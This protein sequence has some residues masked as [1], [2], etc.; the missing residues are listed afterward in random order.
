MSRGGVRC[1]LAVAAVLMAAPAGAAT[2]SASEDAPA[3]AILLGFDDAWGKGDRDALMLPVSPTF[4]CEL[5]GKIDYGKLRTTYGD[6]LGQLPGSTCAT[7]ILRL[8]TIGETTQAFVCRSIAAVGGE[9]LEQLCHV[10]YL[11]QEGPDLKIVGL[12][13]YDAE[14]LD[15]LRGQRYESDAGLF[16]LPVPEGVFLIPCPKIGFALDRVLLRGMDLQCEIELFLLKT[17]RAYDLDRA[18]DTDLQLWAQE[19]APAKIE[20]RTP[21]QVAGRAALRAQARYY[22]A[23]CAL[24]ARQKKVERRLI[25]VY[26]QLDECFLLAIDLRCPKALLE[27]SV[28]VFDPLLASLHVDVPEGLTYGEAM[29][30][31]RGW[32][33]VPNNRFEQAEAGFVLEAPPDFEVE[34]AESGALFSLRAHPRRDPHTTIQIDGVELMDPNLSIPEMIAVD[35]A[36]YSRAAP[37]GHNIVSRKRVVGGRTVVQVDR[38]TQEAA[39]DRFES[40][41]YLRGARYLFTVRVVG[42]LDEVKRASSDLDAILT[43]IKIEGD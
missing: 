11:Q 43:R 8:S 41:I 34:A 17:C 37:T 40:V 39:S 14:G 19:N 22:G 1:A 10:I 13:E 36:A 24:S 35:D 38:Q 30:A 20:L 18:L 4:G 42:T 32:G 15:S 5:Y 23:E 9:L 12:E 33:K 2:Q 29:K 26:V 31:R 6:L 16:S 7:E 21:V 28:A 27:Q 25:R 3:R